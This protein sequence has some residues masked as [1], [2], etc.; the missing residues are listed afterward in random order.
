MLR[1]GVLGSGF[2]GRTHARA[3]ARLPDVQVVG[4]S[5]LSHEEAATLAKEVNARPFT[6]A[7]ALATDPTVD[8]ISVTLPTYLH[9]ELTRHD[10]RLLSY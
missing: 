9:K 6:D 7:T 1:V 3:Y 2:M 8:A 4:V 5:S 10:W